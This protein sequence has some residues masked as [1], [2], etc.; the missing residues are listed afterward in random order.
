MGLAASL[1]LSFSSSFGQS[2]LIN[3]VDPNTPGTDSA[4]F[5][6]LYDGGSGN[7]SLDGYVLVFYNGN[8]DKVIE[9]YDLAGLSTNAQGIF[10]GGNA[11][12]KNSALEIPASPA[13]LQNGPDGAALYFGVSIDD[14]AKNTLATSEGLVDAI[15][16]RTSNGGSADTLIE[17]LIPGQD[18]LAD[19]PNTSLARVPDGGTARD[20]STWVNQAPTP[21]VRNQADA[22]LN[23]TLSIE[24]ST[25]SETGAATTTATVTRSGP[26]G[27]SQ[28]ILIESSDQTELSVP[29]TAEFAAGENTLTFEVTSVDDLWADGTQ[30]V[31]ITVRTEDN[32][33]N[34]SEENVEVEDDGDPVGIVVNEVYPAVNSFDGDANGDG[35]IENSLD[36]FVE[37][38]NASEKDIDLGGFTLSES[39]SPQVAHTFPNGTILDSGCALVVFGGGNI[40]EGLLEEFGNALIQ[41]S[42][43]A[44]NEFGLNLTNAGDSISIR[45]SAGIEIAGASWGSVTTNDGSLSRSP[46]ITGEFEF[47]PIAG[48]ESFSP[49]TT[50]EGD[51]FCSADL[52]LSLAVADA[53]IP[54]DAGEK[55]TILTIS[56]TGPTTEVL[57]V[58]LIN[59]DPSEISIPA[60]VTIPS[61]QAS[62]DVNVDAV[63]DEGADDTQTVTI[64]ASAPGFV[65]ARV[66]IDVTDDGDSPV[67]VVI[68]EIDSDQDGTDSMEFIELFDGGIGNLPLDGI[69]I[70]LY[71]GG[72]DG[73]G[74]NSY[75]T[76][77]LNGQST[78]ENGFF[79][80]GQKG[81]HPNFVAPGFQ[82]QNGAD[83]VAIY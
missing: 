74:V 31:T 45:N 76:I 1:L 36:E 46:D 47:H 55:A 41:K 28:I 58:K 50:L 25:I 37:L 72:G 78:D 9:A 23:L 5:I 77:D 62:E 66:D 21:G 67:S 83:A 19:D 59:G 63:N 22:N 10:V 81:A 49:G 20:T 53:T 35:E 70:V 71:N 68:N 8:G 48:F 6:E 40:D 42:N 44:N 61:G 7:T 51:V 15:V 11:D 27:S 26:V 34:P 43:G 39:D 14:L 30:T 79:T 73:T 32:S 24:P 80:V 54:E 13:I 64:S 38:V 18:D 17:V 2:V 4:E 65:L 69:I 60:E 56:R 33:L 57:V 3:E 16:W 82:L 75:D 12:V 29:V 52:E